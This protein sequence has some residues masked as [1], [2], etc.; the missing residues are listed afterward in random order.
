MLGKYFPIVIGINADAATATN[1]IYNEIKKQ[2]QEPKALPDSFKYI[3]PDGSKQKNYNELTLIG[4][5]SNLNT[6]VYFIKT[7]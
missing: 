1:Q 4:G 7:F 6:L 5:I 3:S 2:E